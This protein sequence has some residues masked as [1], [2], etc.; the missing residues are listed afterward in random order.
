MTLKIEWIGN[1]NPFQFV[2]CPT[3]GG[4]EF[5]SMSMSSIWCDSC[6]TRFCVRYTAGD[7]GCVVDA[8][9]KDASGPIFQC[10]ECNLRRATLEKSFDCPNCK[11]TMAAVPGYSGPLLDEERREHFMILK[12]GDYCSGWLKSGGS[13]PKDMYAHPSC[14]DETLQIKWEE[15]QKRPDFRADPAKLPGGVRFQIMSSHPA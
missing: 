6:N 8:D 1:F 7:P 14:K 5:T 12:L 10:P 11:T 2:T 15:F 13:I 3:C 9:S 4:Q